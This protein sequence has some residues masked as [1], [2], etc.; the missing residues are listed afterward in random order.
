MAHQNCGCLCGGRAAEVVPSTFRELL[1]L[2]GDIVFQL[3]VSF[4]EWAR[5]RLP[6]YRKE[7][8]TLDGHE[9]HC[10]TVRNY[11]ERVLR[12][13]SPKDYVRFEEDRKRRVRIMRRRLM[14]ESWEHIR[15][16]GIGNWPSWLAS[17]AAD[18]DAGEFSFIR[19][20]L[21]VKATPE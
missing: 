11:G 12:L 5:D 4:Q 20:S 9:L 16:Y 1:R 19:L 10:K 17:F 18:H 6:S 15:Q 3:N 14:A 8:P 13:V 21:S 7:Y 2:I